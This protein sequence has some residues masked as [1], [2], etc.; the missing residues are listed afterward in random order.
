MT[1][2]I[3]PTADTGQAPGPR[4]VPDQPDT[5][6]SSPFM[7][8]GIGASAGGL[9]AIDAFFSGMAPDSGLAFVVVQ[10]LS[11]DYKSLMVEILTK[12]T[13]MPVHRAED[14]MEVL[15][16]NVYLIP[17]KTQ[18]TIFKGRLFLHEQEHVKGVLNLPIDV[19]LHSLAEDQGE[20]AVGVILSGTGSDGMRGVRTIKE[21][22]GMVM[23]QREETAKFDGMPRS[24]ISTGL[25]DY[26]LPPAEMPEC[27]LSY[28]KHPYVAKKDRAGNGTGDEDVLRRIFALLHDKFKV[29]FTLYRPSTVSRRIERR[30]S[31]NRLSE[32]RDYLGHMR[33]HP[34]EASILFREMLIG[35]TSFFRD[36][37]VFDALGEKWL[38][39]LLERNKNRELRFWVA[40]CSTG[41][42]AYTLAILIKESMLTAGVSRDVKI[43]ATDIDRDAVVFAANGIYPESIVADVPPELLGKHFHCNVDS[44]QIARNIREMVVFAQHNL[45]KDPPF[46]RIDMITCRNLMI[47]LQPQLQRKVLECFNF[48]LNVAGLLLL[49]TSETIGEM[50]DCFEPLDQKRKI[51]RTKGR[52]VLGSN[53]LE[54]ARDLRPLDSARRA[55]CEGAV[56]GDRILER[57]MEVL[58]DELPLTVVVNEKMEAL[59]IIGDTEGMFKVPSGR[60][61]IEI[62]KMVARELSIPLS[63]GIQKVFRGNEPMR[64]FNI[65]V[66]RGNVHRLVDLRIHPLPP[67][68]G[69]E[70]LA[71]VF[72][73]EVKRSEIKPAQPGQS[74]DV[75]Q[76]TEQRIVDLEQEL[77]FSKENLQATVEELEA[78]N[79]ELQATNEELL[80]SNE[81][82]QSTN[83][84]LQSTN[85]ELY[86]VN[87]E[88]QSKIME[89]S[90]LQSDVENLLS[91]GQIG[92]LLLDE[93]MEIRR[94]SP[95]IRDIF[96]LLNTDVGR[97]LNHIN[98]QLQGQDPIAI[99]QAVQQT[100]EKDER[101]VQTVTGRW[102][103]MRVVPY[104]LTPRVFSGT[105]VSFMDIT[106]W[107]ELRQRLD[108][109]AGDVANR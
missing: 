36:R 49:G 57:L 31:I 25:A 19:F 93:N 55:V 48:S 90:Q 59:H 100:G 44:Y 80:A 73:S 95:K 54:R 12:K 30:M 47:Y 62:S 7:Y 94:F 21:Y 66:G 79:E 53:N 107:V 40:G 63:T 92:Q 43:F 108:A 68:K 67:R 75:A 102:H 15:A 72:L 45:I 89:L 34:G 9:E 103:L 86:T 56:E 24:A 76:E 83:E 4:P 61:S 35:V 52:A 71:V 2:T 18:L 20:K 60:P 13:A 105:L 109:G 97:P 88:Y 10:H 17:P 5:A 77:M 22:G 28:A 106:Q 87:T 14:G 8:V 27:L 81:E 38:P 33:S 65:R 23:V 101:E 50:G 42:E 32:L 64:F 37:Q 51:Y 46:T 84:E 26:I 11:P 1:D 29:D 78:S 82:L 104:A 74:Y 3:I 96:Q 91:A 6:P 39:Q 85:E 98:H 16:D 69:R 41:E 99:I 70:P 58:A